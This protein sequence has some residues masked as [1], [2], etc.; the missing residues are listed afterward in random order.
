MT[1]D[2]SKFAFASD[3]SGLGSTGVGATTLVIPSQTIPPAGYV[4]YTAGVPLNNSNAITTLLATLSAPDNSISGTWLVS[5]YQ[6]CPPGGNGFFNVNIESYYSGGSLN[7]MVQ[8]INNDNT[9][10][11]TIAQ[12]T[13][14]FNATVFTAPF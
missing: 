3:A 4:N 2:I 11:L 1:L 13:F 12:L 5:G 6:P 8:V 7:A 10:P 14:V 9:Y